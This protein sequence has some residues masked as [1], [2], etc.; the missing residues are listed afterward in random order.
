MSFINIDLTRLLTDTV[1][2]EDES[3]NN[4]EA[5]KKI[6]Q[7]ELSERAKE[8]IRYGKAY[9]QLDEIYQKLGVWCEEFGD[10]NY[11]RSKYLCRDALDLLCQ[12]TI[13]LQKG[14]EDL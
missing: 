4:D 9:T 14:A 2:K 8:L 13:E 10:I 6:F 11:N 7:P 1:T 3:S 12:A 5:I